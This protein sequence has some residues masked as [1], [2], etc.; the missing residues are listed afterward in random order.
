MSMTYGDR[1]YFL[2]F[3]TRFVESLQQRGELVPY[4]YVGFIRVLMSSAGSSQSARRLIVLCSRLVDSDATVNDSLRIPILSLEA[5]IAL[6]ENDIRFVS[7][8]NG[9]VRIC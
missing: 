5:S 2:S 1:D 8:N 9:E 6:E 3:A 7:I 4:L